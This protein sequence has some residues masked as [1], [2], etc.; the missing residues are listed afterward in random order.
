MK[1]FGIDLIKFI[2]KVK[3]VMIIVF[4]IRS[5]SGI[6]FVIMCVVEE[7]MG[8]DKGIFLFILLFGVMINMDGI[9]FY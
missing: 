3:D 1:V 4:V 6:F 9:V 8:V 5:L 7:E 2:R